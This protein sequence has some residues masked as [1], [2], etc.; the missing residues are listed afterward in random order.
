YW[1][2]DPAG[3]ERLSPEEASSVGFLSVEWKRQMWYTSWPEE[4]YAGLRQF[5]A[6]KGFD[7]NSQ[8]IGRH[9]GYPLFELS[10]D[11]KDFSRSTNDFSNQ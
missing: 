3:T 2:L 8:D 1:S 5:H 11:P 10:S 6:T 7:P 4:V 9:L